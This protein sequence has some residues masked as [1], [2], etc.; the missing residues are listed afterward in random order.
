M[1]EPY[2][3]K[4]PQLSDTMTEGVIVSWEKKVGDEIKRGDIVATSADGRVFLIGGG[5]RSEAYRQRSADVVGRSVVVPDTDE[6]VST[7]AA[8][9]AAVVCGRGS[10]GEVA[11]E[12]RLG[13]GTTIEPG[14]DASAIRDRYREV[15]GR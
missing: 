10:F 7:G 14:R 2:I 3:I 8:V 6:T 13:T 9:Q 11:D 1:S 15:A 5:A 4:M 12:W